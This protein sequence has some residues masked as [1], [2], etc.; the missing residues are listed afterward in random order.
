MVNIEC[1]TRNVELKSGLRVEHGMMVR[2]IESFDYFDKLSMNPLIEL[3]A[4]NKGYLGRGRQD[5]CA[6]NDLLN[7]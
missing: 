1:R 5:R 4:P 7:D 3:P 6:R 2:N